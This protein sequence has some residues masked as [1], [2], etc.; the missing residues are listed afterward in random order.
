MKPDIIGIQDNGITIY[1]ESIGFTHTLVDYDNGVPTFEV[2]KWFRIKNIS[3]IIR[4]VPNGKEYHLFKDLRTLAHF[5][6]DAESMAIYT[7]KNALEKY[8]K[9]NDKD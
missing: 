4:S 1:L 7:I 6:T 2:Y 9:D 3:L 8:L 5:A